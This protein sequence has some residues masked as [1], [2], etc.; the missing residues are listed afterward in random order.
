MCS[1]L[2]RA[3]FL[4]LTC[5]PLVACAG[6]GSAD[7]AWD[8]SS[9]NTPLILY[10]CWLSGAMDA[11]RS[12]GGRVAGLHFRTEYVDWSLWPQ[13][14]VD[15]E[16]LL[17]A[18]RL[19]Y[20][21]PKADREPRVGGGHDDG[22][23]AQ[24]PATVQARVPVRSHRRHMS[25]PQRWEALDAL[26]PGCSGSRPA[27]DI[28]A[29]VV[30]V[31]AARRTAQFRSGESP[32]EAAP[33]FDVCFHWGDEPWGAQVVATGG[34]SCGCS[35]AAGDQSRATSDSRTS[36]LEA[37]LGSAIAPAVG[38]YVSSLFSCAVHA[39]RCCSQPSA[40]LAQE[41]D[42]ETPLPP[43]DPAALPHEDCRRESAWAV[44]VTSDFP[45]IT[46]IAS[47]TGAAHGGRIFTAAHAGN[48]GHN[49][50]S[51]GADSVRACA[52]A[53]H[54]SEDEMNIKCNGFVA[55]TRAA[56][57]MADP[58]A[59]VSRDIAVCPPCHQ[60]FASDQSLLNSLSTVLRV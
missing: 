31:A 28:E 32:S 49:A 3:G 24:P 45:P 17:A 36:G 6:G 38:G 50:V 21:A 8:L 58:E 46:S 43:G 15:P 56:S 25:L 20:A 57:S 27:A 33:I 13:V 2:C 29:L 12:G 40:E 41:S 51:A 18:A 30:P 14:H 35:S 16:T 59:R 60:H 55:E 52:L 23:G 19:A 5:W 53:G 54:A 48:I 39:S 37:A 47:A 42:G 10:A 11:A 4:S 34:A 26:F 22:G 9:P 44:F 1:W 7:A